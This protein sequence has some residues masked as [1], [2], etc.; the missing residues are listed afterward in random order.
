[1]KNSDCIFC[2]IIQKQAFA[3][4]LYEDDEI[5]AFLDIKPINEGHTLIIPKKHVVQVEELEEEL[6]LKLFPLARKI[7]FKIKEKIPETTGFNYFIADGKDAGQEIFHVHLHVIPRKP[8]DGFRFI[9]DD[10]YYTRI[11]SEAERKIVKDKLLPL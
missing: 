1:M 9:F 2:R 8:N 6:Y 3:A 4:V 10:A 11:L 7:A 5:I